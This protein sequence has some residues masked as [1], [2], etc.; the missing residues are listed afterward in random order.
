MFVYTNTTDVVTYRPTIVN[1][2]T[3]QH[4][5]LL[6]LHLKFT[7]LQQPCSLLAMQEEKKKKKA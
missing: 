7:P 5:Y 6:V 1:K 2:G 3:N 4:I